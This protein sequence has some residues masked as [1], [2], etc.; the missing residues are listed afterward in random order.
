MHYLPL[1][2]FLDKCFKFQ[3]DVC[4]GCCNVLMMSMNLNNFVILIICGVGYCYIING[5][6]ESGAVNLLQNVDLIE[7]SVSL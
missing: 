6:S 5:I 4:I 2:L 1:L 3:T 7:K